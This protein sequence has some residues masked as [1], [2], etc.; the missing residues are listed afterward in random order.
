V[1]SALVPA[2]ASLGRSLIF[3]GELTSIKLPWELLEDLPLLG[4]ALPV[5]FAL[6]VIL[7]LA[8]VVAMWLATG[9]RARWVLGILVVLS[10]VPL[11]GHTV[12]RTDVS[13]PA[14]FAEDQYRA[15]LRPEDRVITIP[16]MGANAR[17]QAKT[18]MAFKL[19]GGYLG[20]N[21]PEGYTRFPTWDTLLT[22]RLTPDYA[23]QLRRFVRAKGVTAI[24]VDKRFTGPWRKLFGSLGVRPLDTG[25][26]LFYRLS[27][28]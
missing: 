19:A 27:A 28:P 21:F 9:G 2:V 11:V 26:V 12:W 13:D 7:P 1:L 16:S 18:D 24:V 20:T 14:F 23:S 22:G 4:H 6:F 25:G 3:R 15:H 10:I 8:L 17:Y 5:R